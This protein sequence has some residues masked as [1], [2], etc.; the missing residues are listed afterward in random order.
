M[1]AI[2]IIL[3]IALIT[4]VLTASDDTA[5][6]VTKF[7]KLVGGAE[8]PSCI[9]CSSITKTTTTVQ[10]INKKTRLITFRNESGKMSEFQ[11]PIEVRNFDQIKVGDTVTVI[12]TTDTDI[13]V[14]KGAL[15]EKSRTVTESL[16]KARLGSKPGVKLKK[17]TVDQAKISDIDYQTRSLTLESMHGSLTITPQNPDHFRILRVG[18]IV[19]A[20]STKTV[21]I[22]VTSP[23]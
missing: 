23:Q 7:A 9:N 5:Q 11:A 12:I 10:K 18:D 20:I 6:Q 22:N 1:K 3:S 15:E 4:T 17:I 13:Q 19:D 14:T 21:E 8:A 16:S 2:P